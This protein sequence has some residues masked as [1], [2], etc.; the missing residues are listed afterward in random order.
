MAVVIGG[1]SGLGRA[2]AV[3]LARHGA[4]ASWPRAGVGTKWNRP[5]GD[6]SRRPPNAL[7]R[8]RPQ[9]ELHRR[10]ARSRDGPLRPRR[11]PD[12]RRRLHLQEAHRRRGRIPLLGSHGHPPDE[13]AARMPVVLYAARGSGHGRVINIASL[14]SFLAFYEVAAYCAAKTAM[15]SLTRSLACEWAEDGIWSTPSRPGSFPPN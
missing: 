11:Y 8:R 1:T 10:A 5:P 4:A 3:G 13:R 12:Q 14:G 6:R 2:L 15:L 9:P 7:P